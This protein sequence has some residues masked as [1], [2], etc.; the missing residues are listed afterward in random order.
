MNDE[1]DYDKSG[2]DLTVASECM[3]LTAYADPGTGG[4]PWTNGV[5]HTGDDVFQGQVITQDQ[6]YE[7][8][9]Q[10]VQDAVGAVKKLVKVSLN[11][12][13]FDS[14]VDFVFNVGEGHFASSTL[15]RLLNEGD[16]A[17]ASKHFDDWVFGGGRK[18]AGLVV[19]RDHEE[20][21]FNG[22]C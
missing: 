18:L 11:Q 12:L 17:G 4:A 15:L 13:Q 5:G 21:M 6:A 14:L 3:K 7:W 1:L 16:Y 2:L 10:D 19:R 9:H 20:G 8:L 22:E